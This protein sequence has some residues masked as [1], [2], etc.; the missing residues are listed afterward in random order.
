MISYPLTQKL[1]FI[2]SQDSFLHRSHWE[3]K[4]IFQLLF[5]QDWN[6]SHPLKTT[7]YVILA[8]QYLAEP[9]SS[10]PHSVMWTDETL[11]T[12]VKLIIL[13]P[14]RVCILQDKEWIISA[15]TKMTLCQ[16]MKIF[17]WHRH[18]LPVIPWKGKAYLYF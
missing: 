16:K 4:E 6:N 15:V 10:K 13:N 17:G 18:F 12:S 14:E 1:K 7:L 8:L 3:P 9:V 5:C 11:K 2:R